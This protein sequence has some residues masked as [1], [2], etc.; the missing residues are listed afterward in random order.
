MDALDFLDV[1]NRLRD[2]EQESDRRTSVG[3][4]YF[5]L[6]NHV[7]TKLSNFLQ[8]PDR[9]DAHRAVA[10]Y[11]TGTNHPN[12]RQVGQSLRDLR[13]SRNT[14]DYN[15]E[16]AVEID[17]SRTAARRARR[18]VDRIDGVNDQTL[19]NAVIAVPRF[20]P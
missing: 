18:A 6:Y 3:R 19:R 5:A 17:Q 7:R 9:E 12:I 16:T 4:S 13:R 8:I 15:L 20:Q 10:Y 1:A 2:S 14:A 11:L